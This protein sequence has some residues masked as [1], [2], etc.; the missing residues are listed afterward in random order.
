MTQQPTQPIL[1]ILPIL[2]VQPAQP[3]PP[4][5]PNI[6][7]SQLVPIFQKHEINPQIAQKLQTLQS[8]KIVFIFDDSGSMNATD[9]G[10]LTRWEELLQFAN[11]S[12]EIAS[13][14]NQNGSDL[15]FLNRPVMKNVSVSS[16]LAQCFREKPQGVTP[17]TR[18]VQNIINDNSSHE[19]SGKNLLLII[20]TDGEPTDADGNPSVP[21]FKQCLQNRPNNVFSTIVA[22]TSDQ[23]S[24]GYL[25]GLDKEMPRLDVCD[26][27]KSEFAEVKRSKGPQFPFSFG[28]YIAKILLGSI[29]PGFDKSD[30]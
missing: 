29:D 18:I 3:V 23:D 24:I 26:D 27:Y 6:K 19:L 14:F 11:V 28:D 4:I 10:T 22:C 1:P 7:P 13:V 15:Y 17:L 20:T 2:P 8:F 12:I 9:T 30:E 5:Q 21:E 16:Q 25:N